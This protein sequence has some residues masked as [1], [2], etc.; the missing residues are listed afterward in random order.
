[1]SLALMNNHNEGYDSPRAP[2]LYQQQMPVPNRKQ[3]NERTTNK[4]PRSNISP[5]G[6]QQTEILRQLEAT[7]HRMTH[8]TTNTKISFPPIVVKFNGEQQTSIKD[9]TD[10]LISKWKN[11]HGIDLA[12]TARFGHMHSLLIFADDSPTFE[13]FLDPNRW[14]NSLKEVDIVILK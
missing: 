3:N 9:I 8:P 7:Q 4:R 12:I 1:M 14:P 5:P 10:D 11:Q 6:Q 2:D 13:S